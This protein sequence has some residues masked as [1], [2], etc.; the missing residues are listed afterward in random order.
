MVRRLLL[1]LLLRPLRQLGLLLLLLG[2]LQLRAPP[3]EPSGGGVSTSLWTTSDM[4]SL[5]LSEASVEKIKH[6]LII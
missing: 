5:A 2:P 6:T 4:L 3:C 1:Q